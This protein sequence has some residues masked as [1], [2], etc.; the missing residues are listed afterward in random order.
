MLRGLPQIAQQKLCGFVDRYFDNLGR[1]DTCCL[2]AVLLQLLTLL[3]TGM[4]PSKLKVR[5]WGL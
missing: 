4:G 1:E 3:V 5:I 2:P